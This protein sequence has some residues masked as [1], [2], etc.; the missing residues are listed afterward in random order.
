MFDT[1]NCMIYWNYL[2]ELHKVLF[3][4]TTSHM[5]LII[6]VLHAY[7][8]DAQTY[9]HGDKRLKLLSTE[10]KQNVIHQNYDYDYDYSLD[11]N[12]L[13]LKDP[14]EKFN[15]KVLIFNGILD[16]IIL[17]P[18]ATIYD[19]V[20]TDYGKERVGNVASNMQEPVTAI[21]SLLQKKP[22]EFLKSAWRFIINSTLGV[23][24]MFDI[25]GRFDISVRPKTFGSTLAYYGAGPGSYL[26][27]PILGFTTT[28]D[29][30]DIIVL[31]TKMNI[32]HY[33]LHPYIVNGT[34]GIG[35]IDKR[36]QSLRFGNGLPKNADIY[37]ILKN[38]YHEN[39]QNMVVYPESYKCKKYYY[40]H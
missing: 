22:Q 23:G 25:A 27:L 5:I 13:D 3:I 29:M 9:N 30:L 18:L 28:R 34:T 32:A 19:K 16:F 12:C 33:Y 14:I 24:G 7:V 17:R 8:C 10:D 35:M 21:N 20:T 1:I 6:L 36:A 15:R 40:V 26:V 4:K 37:N 2:K 39:R 11:H 38:M 31:N